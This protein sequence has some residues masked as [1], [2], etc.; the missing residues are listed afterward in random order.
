M[1]TANTTP[2]VRVRMVLLGLFLVQ[3]RPISDSTAEQVPFLHTR[4]RG[5]PTDAQTRVGGD[6]FAHMC[7][8]GVRTAVRKCPKARWSDGVLQAAI[9]RRREPA[10]HGRKGG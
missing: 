5:G 8:T 9:D 7:D 6:F 10:T 4:P 3:L 1:T 2:T